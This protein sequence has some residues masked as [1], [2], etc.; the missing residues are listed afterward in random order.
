[1]ARLLRSVSLNRAILVPEIHRQGVL[2]SVVQLRSFA[3]KGKKKS[4]SDG[5][6]SGDEKLSKK[7]VALHQA[8][9]QIT[10]SFG[11]GAIMWLGRSGAGAAREVP[12]ISTGLFFLDMALGIGGLPRGRVVEIYG[13]EAS[14]KTTLALHLIAEAQK[15]GGYCA[16]VDAEHALDPRLAETIGVNIDNLLISQPDCGE[17]ALSL[18]DTLI[19]SGSV[20]VVVVDSVAALVP[21]SELEGEMGDAHM[22][23]QARLMSQALR[24]LSH[25]LS[26][27]QTVLLF[28]NQVR[29]KLQTFGFGGTSEVTSGGN[30]LKYYSSVRLNVRRVGSV[31][32]GEEIIGSQILVKIM[33]NKHAPPFRTAQ[34]E[35]EYG[36]GISCEAEI[37][38]LGCKHKLISVKGSFYKFNGLT[39]HGKDAIKRYFAE[40]RQVR[41]ELATKVR[42]K[43]SHK[44]AA[45]MSDSENEVLDEEVNKGIVISKTLDEDV[46]DVAN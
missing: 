41:D 46:V 30:A 37:I 13:P 5:S 35:L 45:I 42:E 14:G 4:K 1:M 36:K 43:I 16:F 12:V 17:Q 22:A 9:D 2:S 8:L 3:A 34:F 38:E 44:D 15:N 24:K 32:R 19:R 7:D 31:K 6:E 39:F 33:K 20:D 21:K 23:L 26:L 10:A 11:T 28:I 18:V 25:S 40:N 27:S 29:S